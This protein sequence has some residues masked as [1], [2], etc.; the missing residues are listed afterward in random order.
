MGG[1]AL[2]MEGVGSI[3]SGGFC[4]AIKQLVRRFSRAAARLERW[5]G[6]SPSWFL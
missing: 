2:D 5:I 6:T 1:Q 4:N 3:D